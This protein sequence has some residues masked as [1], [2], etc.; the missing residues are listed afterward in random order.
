MTL[1][2]ATGTR[3]LI[4]NADDFGQSAGITRGVIEAHQHGIVTSASL[5]V[6]WPASAVAAAYACGRP[7]MS[8]GLHID[9]GEWLYVN[10]RWRARYQRVDLNDPD[11]VEREVRMQLERFQDLVGRDPTHLDSHQHV[12]RREPVRSVLMRVASELRVPLRESTPGIRH[13]GDFYGQGAAGEPLPDFISVTRLVSSLSRLPEGVTELACHPGY[14]ADLDTMYQS[15]RS[16]EVRTLCA[17][18]VRDTL[19]KEHFRLTSFRHLGLK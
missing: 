15:E 10:G 11:A 5:M 3:T 14:A 18:E 17:D 7:A 12:H 8:G 19:A 13:R 4:V 2:R 1:H 6:L 16:V 9:L